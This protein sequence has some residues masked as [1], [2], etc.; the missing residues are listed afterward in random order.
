MLYMLYGFK[1][2]KASSVLGRVIKASNTITLSSLKSISKYNIPYP[3][4]QGFSSS[5]LMRSVFGVKRAS[6]DEKTL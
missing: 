3:L 2:D 1:S 4:S 5:S 6:N